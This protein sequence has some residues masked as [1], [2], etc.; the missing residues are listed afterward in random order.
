LRPIGERYTLGVQ[1][2]NS[3]G[4][5]ACD[6]FITGPLHPAGETRGV[7]PAAA[8]AR[9]REA[10]AVTDHTVD[11]APSL[12]LSSLRSFVNSRVR[13]LPPSAVVLA[14]REI[15][16]A[17]REALLDDFLSSVEGARFEH[18]PWAHDVV[19]LA[20]DFAADYVDG[21]PLRWSPPV[22][23]RFVSEWLP[24]RAAADRELG[25]RVGEVL[26]SWVRYAGRRWGAPPYAVEEA[27]M[28]VQQGLLT[29][30]R[31]GALAGVGGTP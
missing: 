11:A 13:L 27:A 26:P 16:D 28:R 12:E 10:L 18:V 1:V 14:R 21:R 30:A 23:E 15:G 31:P 3:R 7:T 19:R 24:H 9:L 22:V 20:I 4:G 8:G 2:D 5:M 29:A 17:E 25:E 6:A